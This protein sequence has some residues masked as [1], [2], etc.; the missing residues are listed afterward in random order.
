MANRTLHFWGQGWADDHSESTTEIVA[1]FNGNQV[2]SGSVT[3]KNWAEE[4][5][6]RNFAE[7]QILFSV[8]VDESVV[9]NI[10]VQVVCTSGESVDLSMVNWT[11]DWMTR[12]LSPYHPLPTNLNVDSVT[13][14]MLDGVPLEKGPD[15]LLFPANGNWTWNVPKGSVFTYTLAFDPSWT[16]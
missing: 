14:P 4:N 9:G 5:Y 3:T 6:T 7:Q 10:P 8:E 13:N 12:K 11:A 16:V 1:S 15:A 2:Y